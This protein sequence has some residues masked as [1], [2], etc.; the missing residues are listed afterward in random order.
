[1]R[2]VRDGRHLVRT[3]RDGPGGGGNPCSQR[4][5]GLFGTVMG[6][7][8]FMLLLVA[9]VQVL[10]NLYA[11]TV[12]TSAAFDAAR[13]VAGYD[14]AVDR[15]GATAEAESEL[16]SRL[17]RYLDRGAITL[18]WTCDDPESVRVAFEAAHPSILPEPLRGLGGLGRPRRVVEVRT[19]DLR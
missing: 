11:T 6:F 3:V 16:R 12:V 8:V 15:C 4:G 2:T 17:G 10:F 18:A 5:S 9:A 14:R 19:E 1:M 7:T 13:Q